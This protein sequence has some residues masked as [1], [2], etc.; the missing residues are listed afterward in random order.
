[1]QPP[2]LRLLDAALNRA[3]EA[4]RS[5]EDYARFVASD[6]AAARRL[7]DLRQALG[8]AGRRRGL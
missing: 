2:V 3:R 4:A 7:K 5:T 8:R 1:M 6:A